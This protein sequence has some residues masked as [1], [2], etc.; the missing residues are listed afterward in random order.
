MYAILKRNL[1]Y[2]YHKSIYLLLP[3]FCIFIFFVT[4]IHNDFIGSE[5]IFYILTGT[6][7]SSN[8]FLFISLSLVIN[9]TYLYYAYILFT[10]D[11]NYNKENIF[12]RIDYKKWVVSILISAAVLNAVLT[13]IFTGIGTF[14]M[15]S[16]GRR[17]FFSFPIV[18][19]IYFTKMFI[20][21]LL[22]LFNKLFTKMSLILLGIILLCPLLFRINSFI[23]V[24][25]LIEKYNIF[26]I[27]CI[28]I[29]LNIILIV[30]SFILKDK[31]IT[32]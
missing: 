15:I 20:T 32:M 1:Y 29:V 3:L 24:T 26:S 2:F 27:L 18:I 28:Q 4:S 16:M 7:H 10:Y 12:L 23:Y 31:K 13:F 17:V 9:M 21:Q 8:T 14:F 5:A 11:I 22:F 19:L 30:I 25:A 6:Y